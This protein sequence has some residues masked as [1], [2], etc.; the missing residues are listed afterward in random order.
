M[1]RRLP[2]R[3]RP[4]DAA[5]ARREAP[6]VQVGGVPVDL[7]AGNVER[8][9]AGGVR[10]VHQHRHAPRP[11]GGRH[12][13]ERHDQRR[14]GADVVEH[15]QPGARRDRGGQRANVALRVVRRKRQGEGRDR[16]PALPGDEGGGAGH[17]AVGMVGEQDLVAGLELDRAQHRIDAAAGVVDEHQVLGSHADEL[18]DPPGSGT[19]PRH[20]RRR[21]HAELHQLADHV[22]RRMAFDL[23]EDR[24]PGAHHRERRHA[25][26]AV[27]QVDAAGLER[28]LFEQT[29][30]ELHF[31]AA[32]DHAPAPAQWGQPAGG[33]TTTT[34]PWRG[35]GRTG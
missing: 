13:R 16:R 1:K 17:A 22:A 29:A 4:Q 30:A 25:D 14:L 35:M 24:R 34:A 12:R 33:G 31:R 28:K 11:A 6:L 5:A 20:F 27:V 15:G 32:T 3:R 8:D 2:L 7:E 21:R 19:Q 26:G 18:R 9:L 23:L 10:T